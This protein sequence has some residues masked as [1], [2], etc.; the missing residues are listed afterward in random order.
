[1]MDKRNGNASQNLFIIQ[2]DTGSQ[3]MGQGKHS[4]GSHMLLK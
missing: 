1:M 4:N 3:T 2:K